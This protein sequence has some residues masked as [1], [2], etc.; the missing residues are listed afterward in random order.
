MSKIPD[1]DRCLL[2][3]CSPYT[4]CTIHPTGVDSDSCLDFREDPNAE[5]EQL[6]EPEGASYVDEELVI[7]RSYYNGEEIV[8]PKRL[9]TPEQQW[10][11]LDTHPL[12]TGHCPACGYRF[13]HHVPDLIHFDCPKC[14][15]VDD[16]V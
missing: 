5:P 2:Y 7:E 3:A 10:K 16:T 6:W 1:C 9:L 15:W 12:F 8:P 4:V 13:S 11:I 14:G